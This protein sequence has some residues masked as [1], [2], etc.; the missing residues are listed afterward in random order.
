MRHSI[1]TMTFAA[2]LTLAIAAAFAGPASAQDHSGHGGGAMTHSQTGTEQPY[3]GMQ[4]RPIKALSDARIDGLLT[5]KGIGYALA[6][7]L[8]SYPGPRHALDMA[9]TLGLSEKQ[10]G[11]IRA[12][13]D[14]MQTRAVVLG[15]EIVAAEE[16]LD[17]GFESR[18]ID[19]RSLETLVTGIAELEGR[20]RLVHLVTHLEM[21][22]ILSPHQ[23]MLYDRMRGYGAANHS[24]EAQ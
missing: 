14:D 16:A 13:F 23:V 2:A 22:A 3:A 5:G 9:E 8:N 1:P 20:L 21:R 10:L 17:D 18:E 24:P 19:P 11:E 4:E 6:A 12:L 7:E 15:K